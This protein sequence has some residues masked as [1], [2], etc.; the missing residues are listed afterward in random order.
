VNAPND[1]G[2]AAIERV[3]SFRVS[4]R[5]C[6][7]CLINLRRLKT[8]GMGPQNLKKCYSCTIE[9]M[10]TGCIT[11]WYS[12]CTA[13]NHKP[14]P[15]VALMAQCITEAELPAIQDIYTRRY[16]RKARKIVKDCS[17]PGYGLFSLLPSDK[18]YRSI[19][20]QTNIVMQVSEDPKVI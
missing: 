1:I 11:P 5:T 3:K 19:R 10:L 4:Q 14:L 7:V 15:R 20:S 18:R 17:H 6:N 2:V 16:L 9:S 12:N 13:L 8:F